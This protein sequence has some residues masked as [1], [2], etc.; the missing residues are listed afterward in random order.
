MGQ[1]GHKPSAVKPSRYGPGQQHI[2]AAVSGLAAVSSLAVLIWSLVTFTSPSY[3]TVQYPTWGVAMG[4]CMI[5]FIL[6]WIPIVAV[7]KIVKAE[8]NLCQHYQHLTPSSQCED[9]VVLVKD[10]TNISKVVDHMGY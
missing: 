8:G 2:V 3:G 4:W 5:A 1:D 6:V 10:N 9:A 7:V